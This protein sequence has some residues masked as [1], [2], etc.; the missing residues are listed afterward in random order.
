ME[1]AE[2]A[3]LGWMGE[4]EGELSVQSEGEVREGERR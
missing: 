3:R 2:L 4:C 1:C